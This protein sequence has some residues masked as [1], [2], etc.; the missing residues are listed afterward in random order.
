M[1][2]LLPLVACSLCSSYLIAIPWE[3]LLCKITREMRWHS[4]QCTQSSPL[5][6]LVMQT[7]QRTRCGARV[8]VE[9]SVLLLSGVTRRR[10]RLAA[11]AA[12]AEVLAQE[13]G[14]RRRVQALYK[15]KHRARHHN[16]FSA[17]NTMAG[18][19]GQ[20]KGARARARSAAALRAA[21]V[22]ADRRRC[23]PRVEF[24]FHFKL[25]AK[26]GRTLAARATA[27]C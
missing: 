20:A 1:A 22:F 10:R 15:I 16:H 5:R 9:L 7:G 13:G 26:K 23:R 17:R 21:L 2:G 3:R 12:A 6:L 25:V 24:F 8:G 18:R 14:K 4:K 27:A 19:G 11:A